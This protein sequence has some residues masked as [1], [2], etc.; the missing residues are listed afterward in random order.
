MQA[1]L[2]CKFI[3]LVSIRNLLVLDLDLRKQKAVHF[4]HGAAA[5]RQHHLID[6][7]EQGA[8]DLN[9][10]QSGHETPDVVKG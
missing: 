6:H 9:Y 5:P 2:D 7:P 8:V 4:V 3:F 1:F 10:P